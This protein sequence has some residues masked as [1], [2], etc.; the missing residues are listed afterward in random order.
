MVVSSDSLSAS[1][2]GQHALL[3]RDV[4]HR[5]ASVLAATDARVWP[6]GELRT[7]ERFLRKRV[8]E[9]AAE[10]ER[11]L[12]PTR[13]FAPHFAELTRDHRQ[14]RRLTEELGR[15]NTR[16]GPQAIARSA[17]VVQELLA[18]MQ[19]HTAAEQAALSPPA[20]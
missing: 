13:A 20:R 5:A 9:H 12:Y 17:D 19:R 2:A 15:T 18:V 8:L 7:L 10:E 3:L 16:P 14:L 1:L 11:L 4:R 6:E